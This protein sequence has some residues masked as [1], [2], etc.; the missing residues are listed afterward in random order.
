[1]TSGLAMLAA[2]PPEV[3]GIVTRLS[4]EYLKKARGLLT[5]QSHVTVPPVSEPMEHL[6]TAE[7]TD[8][9]GD[10]VCRVTAAWRLDVR[11]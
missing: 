7:I 1:V 5:A 11:R 8:A 3:R 9:V 4:A 6:I 10:V 2:V